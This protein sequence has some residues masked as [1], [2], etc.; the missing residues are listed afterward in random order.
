MFLA[1]GADGDALAAEGVSNS[2]F[3][4]ELERVVMA[5][6]KVNGLIPT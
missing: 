1:M 3:G 5:F 4:H 2:R 6:Y